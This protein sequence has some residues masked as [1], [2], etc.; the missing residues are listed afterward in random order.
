LKLA[1][2]EIKTNRIATVDLV[3]IENWAFGVLNNVLVELK[4][5]VDFFVLHL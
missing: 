2:S 3:I 1:E 5:L 4:K